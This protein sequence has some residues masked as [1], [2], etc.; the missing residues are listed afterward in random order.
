MNRVNAP[1]IDWEKMDNLVPA[2]VQHHLS[3]R[4]LMLGYM[5]PDAL[6]TTLETGNVTFYSRSKNRLWTKGESSGNVLE[7]VTLGTDCDNDALLVQALPKGPTCH[8][9]VESCFDD[10]TNQPFLNKLAALVAERADADPD[11]SYTASLLQGPP[12]RVAQK[13]GEEGVEVALAAATN[14]RENLIDESADLLYHLTVLLEQ[15]QVPM[16]EVV[17]RLAQRH[18]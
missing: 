5:N 16:T 1:D 14:D 18:R 2:V 11:S 15:Q 3:G 10:T 13:V 8:L 12:R 4:V 9:G 17:A 7:L 6:A